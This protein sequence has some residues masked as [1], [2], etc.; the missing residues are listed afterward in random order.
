LFIITKT[1]IIGCVPNKRSTSS[2]K[3]RNDNS[4]NE[5]DAKLFEVQNKD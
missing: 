4:N 5:L 1:E 3:E 2:T